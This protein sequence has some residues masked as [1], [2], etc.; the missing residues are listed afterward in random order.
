MLGDSCPYF[1][2]MSSYLACKGHPE[3]GRPRNLD[4]RD[5]GIG[6]WGHSPSLMQQEVRWASMCLL[7][8]VSCFM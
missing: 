3:N 2:L 8:L 6:R 5:S 7:N 4:I 1:C